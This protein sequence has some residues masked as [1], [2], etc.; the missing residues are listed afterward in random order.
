MF[1]RRISV[2]S[3]VAVAFWLIATWYYAWYCD[4]T[5]RAHLARIGLHNAAMV[6]FLGLY[7][8]LAGAGFAGSR[9]G[10]PERLRG[11]DYPGVW[12]IGLGVLAPG[13]ACGLLSLLFLI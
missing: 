13:V 2:S 1:S 11:K 5:G 9:Y 4:V 6:A 10:P 7:A 12:Q 3:C 8:F